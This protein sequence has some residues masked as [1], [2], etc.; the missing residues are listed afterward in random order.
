MLDLGASRSQGL[1]AW[2]RG[3]ELVRSHG[4]ALFC[5]LTLESAMMSP[6]AVCC[7]FLPAPV[8][9]LSF[10]GDV[11]QMRRQKPSQNELGDDVTTFPEVSSVAT[12]GTEAPGRI[13]CMWEASVLRGARALL[14]A[15]LLPHS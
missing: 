5:V 3:P 8:P 12:L 6:L 13:Q 10:G 4:W 9:C 2:G 7:C 15:P 14:S 11:K 1:G